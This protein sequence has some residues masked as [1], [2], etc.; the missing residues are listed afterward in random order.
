[1]RRRI[2]FLGAVGAVLAGGAVSCWAL[3]PG[4]AVT[5]VAEA[6]PD[7]RVQGEYTGRA[8]D[9]DLGVQ[10]IVLGDGAFQA[11][12]H[13]GGLPGAGW[14]KKTRIRVEGRADGS[15]TRFEGSG[16][17]GT[18]S[19]GTFEGQTAEGA[20][21]RLRRVERKSLTLGAKPPQGAVV[22]FDGTSADAWQGGRM[23]ADGLLDAGARTKQAFG[24]FTIHFEFRTPFMPKARGQG[25]GN[26]GLYLQDRYELQI[27]DSFGLDG[28]NNECGGFY[29]FREPDQNMCFP[30]LAWQTYD[31]DFQAARFDDAGKKTQNALV[32]VKH[33]G[34]VIHDRVELPNASPGGRPEAAGPGPFQVQ[35]HGNPV[36]VRNV[37]VLEKK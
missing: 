26:S 32:T 24:D 28:K 11:V 12:F 5:N 27:L 25:R 7:Y 9:R 22:L 33:N 31:I 6:G 18:I 29:S 23:T 15:A 35:N 8:G 13:P 34:V 16:W 14:D 17:K 1:M 10:V 3:A 21:F 36:H 37:W 19:D 20:S 30:P 4:D 2:L